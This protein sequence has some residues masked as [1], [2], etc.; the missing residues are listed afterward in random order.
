M[1][2][3]G[4]GTGRGGGAKGAKAPQV[5]KSHEWCPL[6]RGKVPFLIKETFFE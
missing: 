5:L 1:L 3:G 4:V 6:L 2:P